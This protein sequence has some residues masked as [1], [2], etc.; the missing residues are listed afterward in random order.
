MLSVFGPGDVAV[1]LG[2]CTVL[3][4][5]KGRGVVLNEPS[6]VARD[7]NTG[8]LLAVG[9]EARKMI[10]R[11]PDSID[12]IRPLRAGVISDFEAT[13]IMLRYF[14][15]KAIGNKVYLKPRMMICVPTAVTS[16]ERRAVLQAGVGAGARKVY[17]VEE[18]LAA[19]VGAGLDISGASGYMVVDVGGGTADIAVLSLNGVVVSTSTRI[20][21]DALDEA[22]VRYVRKTFQLAVGEPTA[23]QARIRAGSLVRGARNEQ[24]ELRGRDLVT[25]LPRSICVTSDDLAQAMEEPGGL[26]VE[27]CR[28]V[29]ERTPPEI[30]SD[31]VEHGIVLTGGG[32]LTHGIDILLERGTGLKVSL[33]DDPVTCVVRG[34]GMVLENIPRFEEHVRSL[35]V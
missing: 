1:D 24:Y 32:A 5:I 19:A 3:V 30:A 23:E 10:G 6:V 2:T 18:P 33:A 20:G 4:H 8:A 7:H 27:A 26:I 11:T 15:K 31:I 25:G 9:E 22:I 12:A 35:I 16:V 14:L 17:L 29:L 13:E 34:A 28:Q 21:G